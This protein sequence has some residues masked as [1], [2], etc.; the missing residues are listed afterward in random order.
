MVIVACLCLRFHLAACHVRIPGLLIQ[1]CHIKSNIMVK[2]VS[3]KHSLPMISMKPLYGTVSASGHR[4]CV[5][6]QQL[7]HIDIQAP[8]AVRINSG[9]EVIKLFHFQL[10]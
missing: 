1:N 9:P 8:R 4:A 7:A 3:A 2:C 5:F 10:C 6:D